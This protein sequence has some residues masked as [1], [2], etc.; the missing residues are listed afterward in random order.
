MLLDRLR[1]PYINYRHRR[2]FHVLRV[3]IALTTTFAVVHLLPLQHSGWALVSTVMVMGN[4]PHI[5]GVLD[6]GRQRLLGTLVGAAIGLLLISLPIPGWGV[7]IGALAAIAVTTWLVFSNRQAYAGLMFAISLL[8]V[9]G[10]GTPD[11]SV[12]LWRSADVL[13]GTLIGIIATV[14]ILPHKATD[15]MRFMLADN[16]DRLARLYHAH[17]SAT[18]APGVDTRELLKA[19]SALLVK[20]RGLADAVHREGRLTRGEVDELISHQ[21]RMLSTI[22]LLLESHWTTREGHDRIDAMHGLRDQQHR[23]ARDLGTLAFH[24]RTG[25]PISSAITPFELQDFAELAGG[26]RGIDGRRLFSPSGYL[27]LN[28]ELARVA[29]STAQHLATLERLPSRRLRRR[30]GR[31]GLLEARRLDSQGEGSR[32]DP[33]SH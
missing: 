23:L 3:S 5:G 12:A 26:A 24:V 2:L 33:G 14:V 30:A 8:L 25:Q 10:N 18:A 4:L 7:Q 17:T 6:K 22:E 11:F 28:R 9:I 29:A 31:H 20:Q 16:L 27:W 19:T 15:V 32:H 21:R 13:V 1:D